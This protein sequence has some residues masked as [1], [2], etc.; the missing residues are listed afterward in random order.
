M[1]HEIVEHVVSCLCRASD[2]VACASALGLDE[3]LLL[4]R[5]C[6][7]STTTVLEAGAPLAVVRA[8]AGHHHHKESERM[9]F[10]WLSAAVRGGRTDVVEWIHDANGAH[11]AEHLIEW[12][13]PGSPR[14][15]RAF[16]RMVESLMLDAVKH[17]CHRVLLHLV[18]YYG[19]PCFH[20]LC[21]IE[22]ALIERLALAALS[23]APQTSI[24]GTLD[25]L[26]GA[27]AVGGWFPFRRTLVGAAA[28]TD[29]IDVLSWMWEQPCPLI[30]G[31]N[32]R[33]ALDDV[34]AFAI[35]HG[36]LGMARWAADRLGHTDHVSRGILREAMVKAASRGYLDAL[37]FACGINW[38]AF[39]AEALRTAFW[40]DHMHILRW[41]INNLTGSDVPGPRSIDAATLEWVR[42][43][44]RLHENP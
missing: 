23:D 25:A 30:A 18:H 37:E 44:I 13:T 7:L 2:V 33:R 10:D 16:H 29:R 34:L 41:A 22:S 20:P 14:D 43:K 11:T 4:A 12:K 39:P 32:K 15:T 36:R 40:N 5:Y 19:R 27:V 28:R 42:S 35:V 8:F 21:L 1:P 26:Y 38:C 24:I 17:G 9:P 6:T 3:G 31:P